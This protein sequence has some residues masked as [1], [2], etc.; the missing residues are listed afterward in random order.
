M[1]ARA[2]RTRASVLSAFRR[3]RRLTDSWVARLAGGCGISKGRALYARRCLLKLGCIRLA[4]PAL[5]ERGRAV[6]VYEFMRELPR[7]R[8]SSP[9]T[10]RPDPQSCPP[11]AQVGDALLPGSQGALG[12]GRERR[13]TGSTESFHSAEPRRAADGKGEGGERRRAWCP[14]YARRQAR[15]RAARSLARSMPSKPRV[16]IPP[17]QLTNQCPR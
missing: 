3:W 9:K 4:G 17:P 1:T 14:L 15:G 10:A 6:K 7:R 2:D 12:R 16:Q 11:R 5:D 8:S 13:S